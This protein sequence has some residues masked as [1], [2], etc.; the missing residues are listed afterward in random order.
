MA[1]AAQES[2]PGVLIV[3]S[4]DGDDV[5]WS[6]EIAH[7]IR[8][9]GRRAV[10]LQPRPPASEASDQS[11]TVSWGENTFVA[12][13]KSLG[14]DTLTVVVVL[15]SK[16]LLETY[17]KYPAL[18]EIIGS[19]SDV[20]DKIILPALKNTSLEEFRK[21]IPQWKSKRTVDA[22]FVT[23]DVI[24]A[25]VEK[26]CRKL[27]GQAGDKEAAEAE[28]VERVVSLTA[29]EKSASEQKFKY[30][31][32]ICFNEDTKP[33]VKKSLLLELEGSNSMRACIHY[34]DFLPGK[35]I[36]TNIIDSIKNSRHVIFVVSKGFEKSGWC[37]YELVSALALIN[38]IVKK[39]RREKKTIIGI[40]A[41]GVEVPDELVGST[42]I[43]KGE[44]YFWQK[45]K[46]ALK[47]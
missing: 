17:P 46:A 5:K 27:E 32:F 21:R 20:K 3:S 45:L 38:G 29:A 1:S 43:S 36:V 15:C 12:R 18:S 28:K 10:H 34:R 39:E 9:K 25:Q 31:M 41:E 30:D 35:P 40:L 8:A 33:W 11:D 47:N 6:K 19:L 2:N 22:D 7:E 44:D 26:I 4:D 42:V 23:S 24:V 37:Q 16:T 13:N 14:D